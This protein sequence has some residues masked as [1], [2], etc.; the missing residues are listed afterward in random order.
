MSYFFI[1]FF[2][3][4]LNDRSIA[5]SACQCLNLAAKLAANNFDFFNA[6]LLFAGHESGLELP[7]LHQSKLVGFDELH[8]GYNFKWL[9]DN[10]KTHSDE[11]E[12]V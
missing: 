11:R 9:F 4:E 10:Y 5:E 8:R 1:E 6:F 2:G 3:A 12:Q 7:I